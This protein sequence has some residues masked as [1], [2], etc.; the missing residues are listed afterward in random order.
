[1]TTYTYDPV[2]GG[3]IPQ[4]QR[5]IEV[6]IN[7]V[8][9]DAVVGPQGPKGDTGAAGAKGDKGDPGAQGPPG[10][11]GS[12]WLDEEE[13]IVRNGALSIG[14]QGQIPFGV[15]PYGLTGTPD[16]RSIGVDR[17]YA[18]HVASASFM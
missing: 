12:R 3:V 11:T 14:Q 13:M 16:F 17:Y 10:S 4:P 5:T 6:T 15:G 1:M 18:K 2:S 7:G 8:S 9:V